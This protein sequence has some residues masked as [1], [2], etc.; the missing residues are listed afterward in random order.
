MM[1]T[2]SERWENVFMREVRCS[3]LISLEASVVD[4]LKRASY[5]CSLLDIAVDGELGV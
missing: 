2:M 1:L 4:E 3:G 5:V